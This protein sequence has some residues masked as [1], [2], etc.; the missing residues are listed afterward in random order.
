[1]RAKEEQIRGLET[2]LNKLSGETAALG[3]EQTE[4][5]ARLEDSQKELSAAE[6]RLKAARVQIDQSR[7]QT[8]AQPP[9]DL[10]PA[11]RNVTPALP[12]QVSARPGV[13]E[14]AR[15]T[16]VYDRPARSGR[17]IARIS[18]GTRINVVAGE[19]EWLEVVSKRGNPPGYILRADARPADPSR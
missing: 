9:R 4:L 1:L 2:D 16:E 7:R 13:Y 18:G 5:K 10:R 12:S 15:A 14:T 3:K 8:A 6:Q 19:G 17:V 11:E